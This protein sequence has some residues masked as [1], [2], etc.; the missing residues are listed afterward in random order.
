MII[1]T[2]RKDDKGSRIK[3]GN[4]ITQCFMTKLHLLKYTRE[5]PSKN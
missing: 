4:F 5:Q 1:K 3:L 2:L